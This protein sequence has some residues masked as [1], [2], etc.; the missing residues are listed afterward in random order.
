MP[1]RKNKL[2]G[3]LRRLLQRLLL[4]QGPMRARY[5]L[6]RALGRRFGFVKN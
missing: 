2:T 1:L 3:A 6:I 4:S 5:R